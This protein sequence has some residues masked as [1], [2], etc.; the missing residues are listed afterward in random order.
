M[1][2]DPKTTVQTTWGETA[3]AFLVALVEM[4]LRLNEWVY[5]PLYALFMV[6]PSAN[7]LEIWWHSRRPATAS[8]QAELA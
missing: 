6:G 1:I 7:L 3:V 5:A 2:T 8:H 4:M